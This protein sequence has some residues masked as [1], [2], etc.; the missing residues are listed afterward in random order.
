MLVCLMTGIVF[1]QNITTPEEAFGF[2]PGT[3][4]K[5]ADWTQ[6][7]GYFQTVSRQSNRVHYEELGKTTEGRPFVALTISSPENLEHANEYRNILRRLA[8]SRQTT[9]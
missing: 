1:G 4:R 7:T 6:L 9:P 2:K 8:D 5:L 3:D